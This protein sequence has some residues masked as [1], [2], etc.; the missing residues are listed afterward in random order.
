[1]SRVSIVFRLKAAGY[2][3]TIALN[4]PGDVDDCGSGYAASSFILLLKMVTVALKWLLTVFSMYRVIEMILKIPSIKAFDN[5]R[6]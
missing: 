3:P 2:L 4:V 5:K 1:M 6:K